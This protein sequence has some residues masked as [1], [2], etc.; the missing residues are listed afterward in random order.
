[1][2]KIVIDIS[3]SLDGFVAGPN[4]ELDAIHRWLFTDDPSGDPQ[5]IFAELVRSTGAVLL[6]RRTYDLSIK[7][8]AFVDTPFQVPHFVVSH[9]KPAERAGVDV[10]FTFVTDGIESAVRQAREAAGERN[11]TLIGGGKTAQEA[12]RAGLIDEITLHVGSAVLGDG[13][14]LFDG[15]GAGSVELERTAITSTAEATHLT[16][17][18]IR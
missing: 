9:S 14:R 17:T 3:T 11:V 12:I 13:I 6:G 8:G 1:M 16:F 10:D 15:L 4:D 18:V 7:Y 2:S 5:R